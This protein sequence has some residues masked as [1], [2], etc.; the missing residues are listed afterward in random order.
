V[1]TDKKL[2]R[3]E[4]IDRNNNIIF[5]DRSLTWQRGEKVSLPYSGERP[6]LGAI[7]FD[8]ETYG[9]RQ[10]V[11][12]PAGMRR[13]IADYPQSP[14]VQIDFEDNDFESWAYLWAWYQ[15]GT[16]YTR[17]SKTAGHGRYSAELSSDAEHP[18][19]QASISPGG[20]DIDVYPW[21]LLWYRIPNGVP[22]KII[23]EGFPTKV[24]KGERGVE[25]A[26]TKSCDFDK[27]PNTGK[28][29]ELIDDDKWHE[30]VMDARVIRS[31]YI[32]VKHL[33]AFRFYTG[34]KTNKEHKFWFDNFRI[35]PLSLVI[36][37]HH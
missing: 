3:V 7:E 23:L 35:L 6:D 32:D 19:I 25:I 2:A 36:K 10:F 1:G 30:I 22:V 26:M 14:L 37:E 8:L 34:S 18:I 24:V 12:L 29:Y 15:R 31:S 28:Q 33:Y 13:E 9:K 17:T 27:G 16:G 20:W 21:I 11:K 4:K 5:L